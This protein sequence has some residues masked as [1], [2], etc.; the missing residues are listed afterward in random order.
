MISEN[1]STMLLVKMIGMFFKMIPYT[2][3]MITEMVA[4]VNIS[5]E[6]SAADLVFH[7]LM[8]CGKKVMEEIHPAVMPK[9]SMAVIIKFKRM[10]I[11]KE[12]MNRTR[13]RETEEVVRILKHKNE[14]RSL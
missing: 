2:S 10:K 3:H 5:N 11:A 6:I 9:I 13:N 7:V 1:K 8:T 12:Q 4:K 14:Y